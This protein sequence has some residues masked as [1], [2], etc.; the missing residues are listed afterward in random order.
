[1]KRGQIYYADLRPVFGSE[2][3]GIRPC[4]IIQNDKGNENSQTVIVAALTTRNK[5]SLPV[6]VKVSKEDFCL[7]INT[8]ILLEQ[9]RTID[10]RRLIKFVG[11]LSDRTMKKVDNAL[12]VSF[13]LNKGKITRKSRRK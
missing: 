8:K 7:N 1:M 4:L 9:I 6:H 10:K 11:M 12:N 3:G 5:K 2:Q 13:S